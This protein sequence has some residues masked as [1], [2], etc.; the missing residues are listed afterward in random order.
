MTNVE[1]ITNSFITDVNQINFNLNFFYCFAVKYNYASV[2]LHGGR[3][4]SLP[5][6]VKGYPGPG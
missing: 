4:R 6:P 2:N 3:S 1:S 5:W